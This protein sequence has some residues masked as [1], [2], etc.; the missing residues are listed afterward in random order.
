MPKAALEMTEPI[1]HGFATPPMPFLCTNFM[2]ILRMSHVSFC[3][4][5]PTH[6]CIR[7]STRED[8]ILI[9]TRFASGKCNPLSRSMRCVLLICANCVFV[10]VVGFAMSGRFTPRTAMMTPGLLMCRIGP[11]EAHCAESQELLH[12]RRHMASSATCGWTCVTLKA[13]VPL[14][15]SN[16]QHVLIS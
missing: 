5:V 15:V 6:D 12:M 16:L 4:T 14:H 11:Q 3:D 7:N 2:Y 13:F 1:L 9:D 8:K 10:R